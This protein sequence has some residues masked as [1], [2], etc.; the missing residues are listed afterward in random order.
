MLVSEILHKP[1]TVYIKGYSDTTS[2]S[3]YPTQPTHRVSQTS[4]PVKLSH[5]TDLLRLVLL[6]PDEHL[7]AKSWNNTCILPFPHH[8][9]QKKIRQAHRGRGN[10]NYPTTQLFPHYCYSL[11]FR[12]RRHTMPKPAHQSLTDFCRGDFVCSVTGFITSFRQTCAL[13]FTTTVPHHTPNKNITLG[14]HQNIPYTYA[15]CS[16]YN[17]PTVASLQ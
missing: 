13:L 5:T 16:N 7:L 15:Y 12:L 6:D 11:S 3:T 14:V 4:N 1:R 17:T 2:G 9:E 10:I 8:A